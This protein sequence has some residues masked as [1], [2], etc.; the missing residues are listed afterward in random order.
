MSA[1]RAGILALLDKMKSP[2]ADF[3]YMAL[4]DFSSSLGSDTYAYSKMDESLEVAA[5]KQVLE[6]L[7]DTNTEVKNLSL[8]HI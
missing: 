3:R 6:L 5:V 1:N 4:N 8:I 2:D 7:H